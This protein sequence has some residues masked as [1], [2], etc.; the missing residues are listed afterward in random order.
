[1]KA[2]HLA[3]VLAMLSLVG[4]RSSQIELYLKDNAPGYRPMLPPTAK[5]VRGLHLSNESEAKLE[6][7]RCFDG[8]RDD[9]G[10]AGQSVYEHSF[11]ESYGGGAA[12]ARDFG[13]MFGLGEAEAG[14]ALKFTGTLALKDIREYWMQNVFFDPAGSCAQGQRELFAGEGVEYV[15]I[16]RMLRAGSVSVTSTDGTHVD[17]SLAVTEFEGKLKA[18]TENSKTWGGAEIHFAFLPQRYN[19]TLQDTHR[20]VRTGTGLELGGCVFSLRGFD[21]GGDLWTG[22]LSCEDGRNYDVHRQAADSI[23]AIRT[24]QGGV[25]FGIRA[26][27]VEGKPGL[28]AVDIA[29][30]TARAVMQD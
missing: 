2:K 5:D 19:I 3:F 24:L 18:S 20:E 15:V 29:R 8:R 6:T 22:R 13:P 12:L 14:A 30:W 9:R 17:L 21:P 1:M 7:N 26:R 27:R 11:D 28:Y 16:T 25:S 23:A 4:C 10:Y